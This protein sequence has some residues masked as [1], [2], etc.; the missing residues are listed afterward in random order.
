[1]SFRSVSDIE[2]DLAVLLIQ[3]IKLRGR[4]PSKADDAEY[5]VGQYSRWVEKQNRDVWQE[6]TLL[7]NEDGDPFLGVVEDYVNGTSD[8]E[9]ESDDETSVDLTDDERYPRVV[10]ALK[11]Y[12]AERSAPL[13]PVGK[14]GTVPQKFRAWLETNNKALLDQMGKDDKELVAWAVASYK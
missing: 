3:Y 6:A 12:I 13:P 5:Y 4:P 9:D 7:I 10:E 8:D 14:R 1:M 2:S 11:Q